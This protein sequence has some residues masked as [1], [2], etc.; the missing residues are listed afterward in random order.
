MA[1]SFSECPECKSENIIKNGGC[2]SCLDCFWS[3]C[4]VA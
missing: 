1:G 2:D 3:A 4:P